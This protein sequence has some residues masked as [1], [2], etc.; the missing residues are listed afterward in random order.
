[1]LRLQL[2]LRSMGNAFFLDWLHLKSP[3]SLLSAMIFLMVKTLK[4]KLSNQFRCI[5]ITW[6][7][8]EWNLLFIELSWTWISSGAVFMLPRAFMNIYMCIYSGMEFNG[9][10]VSWCVMDGIN[11]SFD[12]SLFM[13]LSLG[14]AAIVGHLVHNPRHHYSSSSYSHNHE[15]F[16]HFLYSQSQ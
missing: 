15:R 6:S 12:P 5:S 3:A 4:N 14:N 10:N 16:H 1:M 8:L 7:R 2:R 11:A 13:I 9:Q